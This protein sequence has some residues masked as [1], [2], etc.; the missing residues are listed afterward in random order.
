MRIASIYLPPALSSLR[1]YVWHLR[2]LMPFFL[3]ASSL[4]WAK[5]KEGLRVQAEKQSHK[6]A[7]G[8]S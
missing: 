5:D 4:W 1:R 6:D 2:R 3:S 8:H 7:E